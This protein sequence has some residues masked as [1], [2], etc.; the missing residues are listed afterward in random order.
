MIPL[1][2]VLVLAIIWAVWAYGGPKQVGLDW[3][4]FLWLI[5]LLLPLLGPTSKRTWEEG[6]T[7][8]P[9]NPNHKRKERH[10][11]GG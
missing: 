5:P 4:S 9:E 8:P 7:M 6:A 3:W 10:E 2:V 1:Y 11:T